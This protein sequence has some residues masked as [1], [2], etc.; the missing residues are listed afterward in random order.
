[1]SLLL[2]D[3]DGTLLLSGGAGIRAM[4]RAFEDVFGI[5]DAFAGMEMAGRTDTF[6]VSGALARAGL[7]DLPE[8][9]D[10]FREA[11]LVLLNEEIQ[12]PGNGRRGVMPGVPSLL[13][14]L[15]QD[16]GLHL[17]LLTGN[18][19]RAAYVKLQHF[20]LQRFFAWG[21]F[22]EDSHD[23]NELG[24]A[25]LRRAEERAIPP[26]A[27]ARAVVIGDTPHDVACARAIGARALA[28]ATGSHSVEAL[29]EAGAD[30]AVS[31]LSDT[32]RILDL[33]R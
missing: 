13:E 26:T 8:H 3:I 30:V 2:F 23:R 1:M 28:V 20:D 18:Y 4:T 32:D 33:L 21:A 6:L 22:G 19:E 12:R 27:R 16:A 9:H 24:H 10:R 11:Y 29:R 5:A 14:A 15:G 7:P 17:A 25:A 31:D